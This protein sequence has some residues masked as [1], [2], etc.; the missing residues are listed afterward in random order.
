MN[1]TNQ[2]IVGPSELPTASAIAPGAG[3]W[4]VL[5]GV[6]L[7]VVVLSLLIALAAKCHFCHQY[8]ASYRHHLL[9]ETGGGNHSELVEDE[10]DDGFTFSPELVS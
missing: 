2:T 10:D 4:L 6:V 5:V 8:Y 7:G 9:P 3:A 1:G